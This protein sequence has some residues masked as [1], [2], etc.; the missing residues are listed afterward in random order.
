MTIVRAQVLFTLCVDLLIKRHWECWCCFS[1]WKTESV[2]YK[3]CRIYPFQFST[4][5]PKYTLC[6]QVIPLA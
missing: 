3:M 6:T 5:F 4:T 2:G 1:L